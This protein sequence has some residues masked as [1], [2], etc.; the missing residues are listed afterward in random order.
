MIALRQFS[1]NTGAYVRFADHIR[2]LP[3]FLALSTGL[4]A[5][6]TQA[7][8]SRSFEIGLSL[9]SFSYDEYDVDGR[10]LDGEQ[11]IVPGLAAALEWDTGAWVL[12]VTGSMH[13]GTVDYT[14]ETQS[15]DPTL[16]GLPVT[17]QTGTLFLAGSVSLG[18]WIDSGRLWFG[19]FGLAGRYWERD[20]QDTTVVSTVGV[21][22]PV[23]G[24][25]EEYYW[26]EGFA[27]VRRVLSRS[28]ASEWSLDARLFRTIAATMRVNWKGDN[29]TL[30]LGEDWGWRLAAPLRFTIDRDAYFAVEPWIEGF[31]FGR[32]PAALAP[33]SGDLILEPASE[34]LNF[35]V[36]ARLGFRF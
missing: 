27:G 26:Q 19:Y 23:S 32:S 12:R 15:S 30:D 18:Q 16:D 1:R 10:F 6:A 14:G 34:T 17:S 11:G 31:E 8:S 2:S 24:L 28:D 5:P 25:Y 29:V 13:S 9:I 3:L 36:E 22:T 4:V 33:S 20:I 21:V 35:G 7:E